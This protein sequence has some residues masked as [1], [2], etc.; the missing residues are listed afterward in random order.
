MPNRNNKQTGSASKPSMLN[1]WTKC[2][3]PHGVH[4]CFSSPNQHL[5]QHNRDVRLMTVKRG[6]YRCGVM[7]SQVSFSKNYYQDTRNCRLPPTLIDVTDPLWEALN[8]WIFIAC[9]FL[10]PA[11]RG[12]LTYIPFLPY[13]WEK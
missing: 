2:A 3:S 6:K 4:G 12:N 1:P 11:L 9:P 13:C 7:V 8:T 5:T 10:I